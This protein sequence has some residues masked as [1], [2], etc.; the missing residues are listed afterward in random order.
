MT[1]NETLCFWLIYKVHHYKSL[2]FNMSLE[3]WLQQLHRFCTPFFYQS[4][5]GNI[6]IYI[7]IYIYVFVLCCVLCLINTIQ[8]ILEILFFLNLA[9]N[10]SPFCLLPYSFTNLPLHF[11]VK[12]LLLVK[13]ISPE[14]SRN[15]AWF[16]KFGERLSIYSS[17]TCCVQEKQFY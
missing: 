17:F 15:K 3:F 14:S 13:H 16:R 10:P 2:L 6:Y 8:H 1:L 5:K 11:R 9:L 7:Y 4:Q 12:V